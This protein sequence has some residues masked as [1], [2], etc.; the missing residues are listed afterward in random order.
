MASE[1]EST[2]S[3]YKDGNQRNEGNSKKN[4]KLMI[5][6]VTFEDEASK[7]LG[8]QLKVSQGPK[9]SFGMARGNGNFLSSWRKVMVVSC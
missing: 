4:S 6:C 8:Q 3:R 1:T 9:P 2:K 5:S 7:C